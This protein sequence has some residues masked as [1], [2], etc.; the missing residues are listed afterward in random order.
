[1]SDVVEVASALAEDVPLPAALATDA[2]DG[3]GHRPLR[4]RRPHGHQPPGQ[5]LAGPRRGPPLLRPQGPSAL[6]EHRALLDGAGADGMAGARA[7]ASA[8][9]APPPRSWPCTSA[10]GPSSAPSTPAAGPGGAV[11]LVFGSRAMIR[12][13]LWNSLTR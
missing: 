11:L 1:M 7:A 12:V 13:D 9:A 4:P 8:F 3:A 10:A 6:D 5:R 2:A